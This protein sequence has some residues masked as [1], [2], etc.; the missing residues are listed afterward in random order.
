MSLIRC[1]CHVNFKMIHWCF[2]IL[3]IQTKG[4]RQVSLNWCTRLIYTM[5]TFHIRSWS[6][7]SLNHASMVAFLHLFLKWFW[8]A[9]TIFTFCICHQIYLLYLFAYHRITVKAW[10]HL[11]WAHKIVRV[12]MP[13]M[14]DDCIFFKLDLHVIFK[15][16]WAN[17]GTDWWW[18]MTNAK[19]V[20]HAIGYIYSHAVAPF[21]NM[22]QIQ[23]QHG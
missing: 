14:W 10:D 12:K 4:F 21:T 20:W 9:F 8:E 2:K 3:S 11:P 18:Q 19:I 15:M 7:S 16:K 1:I 22:D 13:K 5:D 6:F 23:S 17:S